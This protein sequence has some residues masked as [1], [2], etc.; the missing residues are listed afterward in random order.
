LRLV[1]IMALGLIGLILGLV[2]SRS[3]SLGYFEP[4]VKLPPPPLSIVEF[5]AVGDGNVIAKT[6]DGSVLRCSNWRH[7]CWVQDERAEY[8]FRSTRVKKPCD[9]SSS[10][11][12]SFPGHSSNIAECIQGV[13]QYHEGLGT[14]IYVLDRDGNSWEWSYIFAGNIT[15]Y[16]M[17]APFCSPLLGIVLGMLLFSKKREG[18]VT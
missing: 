15:L 11:F 2:W 17:F 1:K 4:W 13:T 12:R 9:L 3:V 18:V 7:E 16:A 6:T 10:K 8:S 5:I 14:Y